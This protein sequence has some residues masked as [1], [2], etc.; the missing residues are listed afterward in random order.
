MGELIV[1]VDDERTF[2][3]RRSV[4]GPVPEI[5]YLRNSKDALAFLAEQW[6]N[7]WVSNGSPIKELWLDHDLG[8]GDDIGRVVNFLIATSQTHH[9][10]GNAWISGILIHSQNPASDRFITALARVGYKVERGFPLLKED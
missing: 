5:V 1:V 4:T 8:N 3:Q 10:W 9:P 6:T 2:H 7:Y